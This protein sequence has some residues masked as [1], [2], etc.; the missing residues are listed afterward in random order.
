MMRGCGRGAAL[1][2][3]LGSGAARGAGGVGNCDSRG[4]G[5]ITIC[6]DGDGEPIDP[7]G[8]GGGDC[9]DAAAAMAA[10]TNAVT[11]ALRIKRAMLIQLPPPARGGGPLLRPP[12]LRLQDT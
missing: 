5:G 4:A 2:S 1:V 8:M 3:D 9:A 10:L 12:Q 7:G 6:G 11:L